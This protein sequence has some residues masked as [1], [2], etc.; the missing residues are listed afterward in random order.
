MKKCVFVLFAVI[1]FAFIGCSTT[2]TTNSGQMEGKAAIKVQ[3]P[4]VLGKDGVPMPD[5]VYVDVSTDEYHYVTGYG[6]MTTMQ[7]S[8]KKAQSEAKNALASWVNTAVDEITYSYTND[9]G[10]ED[11]RQVIDA[12]EVTARQR[13]QAILNGASQEGMW[14]DQEG[15][16]WVLMSIPVANVAD[17]MRNAAF[18]VVKEAFKVDDNSFVANEAAIIANQK[19]EEAIE[20]YF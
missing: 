3:S 2:T 6:K 15:G 20:K 13:A 19:L 7:T 17:Q 4:D 10:S 12:F 5:W 14:I 9:S 18:D 11:N 16:I 1:A 8:V